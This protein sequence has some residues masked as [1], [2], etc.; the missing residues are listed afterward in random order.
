[1]AID[2][3]VGKKVPGRNW[4][5]MVSGQ[6]DFEIVADDGSHLINETTSKDDTKH[7]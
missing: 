2:V 1:M 5:S 4:Q 7:S 3:R 6:Q